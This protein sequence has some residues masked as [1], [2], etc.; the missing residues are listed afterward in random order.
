MVCRPMDFELLSRRETLPAG[1]LLRGVPAPAARQ[2][3]VVRQ[4]MALANADLTGPRAL[5]FGIEPGAAGALAVSG[6]T[7]ADVTLLESH[8]SAC[9]AAVEPALDLALVRG[10]LGGR[11]VAALEL[12]HCANPPYV[13]GERAL[14]P[15]RA[16][17]CWLF[18]AHG[19][20]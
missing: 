6:L 19:L 17:E 16:G 13:L 18:D 2:D 4:V 12:G 8:R 15:L 9:V 14:A 1:I 10:V 11:T 20:R 5:V 7:E 3:H